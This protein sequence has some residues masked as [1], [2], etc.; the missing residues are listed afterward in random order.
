MANYYREPDRRQAHGQ[1]RGGT[2]AARGGECAGACDDRQGPRRA[3]PDREGQD[4]SYADFLEEVLKAE[5]DARRL[6]ARAMLM[7]TAGFPALKTLEAY[8]IA[9]ATGAPRAQIHELA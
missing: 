1:C 7:R 2:L 8:D 3:A 4:A 5:R 9:F 6:R